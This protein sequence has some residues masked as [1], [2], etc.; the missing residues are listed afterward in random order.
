MQNLAPNSIGRIRT[1]SFHILACS[2][3]AR[4]HVKEVFHSIGISQPIIRKLFE[5]YTSP[6]NAFEALVSGAFPLDT[7]RP[8]DD[9]SSPQDFAAQTE[10]GKLHPELTI[11]TLALV[12][13]TDNSQEGGDEVKLSTEG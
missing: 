3:E 4:S 5:L 13:E 2:G 6:T 8:V 11:A 12:G 1:A 7:Q 10:A 9:K